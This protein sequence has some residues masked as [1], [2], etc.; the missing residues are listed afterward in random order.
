MEIAFTQ[1]M[2]PDGRTEPVTIDRPEDIGSMAGKILESGKHR[3]ECEILTTNQVSVTCFDIEE[4]E[5]IAI[6]ISANGPAVLA[7]I[8]KMITDAFGIL[9]H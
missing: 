5:D 3:F 7:A 2:L 6:E 9:S 8:D 1:Y 4:E